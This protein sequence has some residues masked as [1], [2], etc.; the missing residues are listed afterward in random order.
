[1]R[2]GRKPKSAKEKEA[3]FENK[4]DKINSIAVL[5]L[6]IR[7]NSD[8]LKSSKKFH[9]KLLRQ[10]IKEKDRQ[11]KSILKF[12][13]KDFESSYKKMESFIIEDSKQLIGELKSI[14]LLK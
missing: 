13:A 4:L 14:K 12:Y 1:M 9:K 3:E 5:L 8:S 2:R 6:S 10:S 7:R 11:T